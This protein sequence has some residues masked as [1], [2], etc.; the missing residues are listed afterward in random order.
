M[1]LVQNLDLYSVYQWS[2]LST[3]DV[4]LDTVGDSISLEFLLTLLPFT[5]FVWYKTWILLSISVVLPVNSECYPG[6]SRRF[7]FLGV[8]SNLVTLHVF[9]TRLGSYSVYQWSYLSTVDVTLD[10][11]GDSISLEFLL[12]LLPFMSLVQDLD[13]IQYI[14]GLT[15][16]QWMLPWIE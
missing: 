9:G 12:T 2:Y 14:S 13:L 15:C 6:Y 8:S 7:Y 16:Q 3:V 5:S 1:S 4:T 10:T 11:V